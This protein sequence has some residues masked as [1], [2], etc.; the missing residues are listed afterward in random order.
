MTGTLGWLRGNPLRLLK[1]V[2]RHGMDMRC[3]TVLFIYLLKSFVFLPFHLYEYLFLSR[4]ISRHTITLTPVFVIGHFRS[5]T[6]MLHKILAADTQFGYFRNYDL[7]LPGSLFPGSLVLRSALRRMICNLKVPSFAYNNVVFDLEDPQEEDM[8][9]VTSFA[10]ISYYWLFVFPTLASQHF[11]R[12]VS[13]ESENEKRQWQQ[14]Y[15][16]YLKHISRKHNGKRLLLKNPPNMARIKAILELFPQAKFI[17]LYRN[18]RDVLFSTKRIW[19]VGTRQFSLQKMDERKLDA[20]IIDIY[21]KLHEQYGREKHDISDQ[22]LIEIRY[23]DLERDPSGVVQ[24]IYSQLALDTK[25]LTQVH[26]KV[27]EER[28][29]SKFHYGTDEAL[30]RRIDR[31]LAKYLD[32]WKTLTS[33]SVRNS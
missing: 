20:L 11:S 21:T 23:E 3:M 6:T 19:Q 24:S 14:E 7:V 25:N 22:N 33:S 2:A 16:Y 4:S 8:C 10:S 9:M 32:Q 31:D 12:Y 30:S 29:Y 28:S 5:G 13:F 26:K 18:P 17:F 15:L 1:M 27:A